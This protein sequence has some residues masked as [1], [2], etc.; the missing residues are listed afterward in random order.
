MLRFKQFLIEYNILLEDKRQDFI[1]RWMKFHKNHR[2]LQNYS[3]EVPNLIAHAMK[4]AKGTDEQQYLTTELLNGNYNPG[5]HDKVITSV[6]G[7]WRKG[8][9]A[10]LFPGL[11][12]SDFTH[13]SISEEFEKHSE[14]HTTKKQIRGIEGL[15]KYHIGSVDSETH[16]P[17]DVYH[18]SSDDVKNPE[19]YTKINRSLSKTCT[20]GKHTW[21][22]LPK[23]TGPELLEKYSKGHGIFFYANE[24]N[25][26]VLSHGYGD[27]NGLVERNNFTLPNQSETLSIK[28]QTSKLLSGYKKTKYDLLSGEH[29]RIS[30]SHEPLVISPQD[31]D[32]AF[33]DK[34]Y[35]VIKAILKETEVPS[36]YIDEAL[37]HDSDHVREA[38]VKNKGFG[39]QHMDQAFNDRYDMVRA[40]A[41]KSPHFGPEHM[42]RALND[43]HAEVRLAAVQSPYFGDE[44]MDRALYDW[45]PGVIRAA[46][47]HKIG[48]SSIDKAINHFR[49]IVR[50]A[51]VKSPNFGPQHMDLALGDS[52]HIVRA[53]AVKGPH[54]GPEHM[55]RALN[56][57]Y[58]F[59][60]TTAIQS[61]HFGPQHM[62]K[63]LNDENE[64]VRMTAVKSPH[65]GPEHI[66]KALNDV[67]GTVRL[68]A[69]RSPH[70]GPQHMDQALNDKEDMV[71]VA[72]V[73]SPNFG[74]EHMDKAL[75]DSYGGVRHAAVWS[76]HFGPEHVDK[77]L[78]DE[79]YQVRSR[80]NKKI[81]MGFK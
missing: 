54:F 43:T 47:K 57:E 38:A 74:P 46:L 32:R 73:E 76:P 25:N 12:L 16:G 36:H 50:I 26:M 48:A 60:R 5:E 65:F 63:A 44:H 62:D 9:E 21:C 75:N 79:D 67:H 24:H 77:A 56:D 78:K 1:N 23:D 72:A 19:E 71:R 34:H 11:K 13:D 17:L 39:P 69:A 61:P 31:M 70:F 20:G 4:F 7:K 3:E 40:E 18:V 58:S 33:Q 10:G 6:L 35:G 68:W 52:S 64:G 81:R 29:D 2:S 22:V 66:D 37:N 80:A 41:V 45:D 14:L 59:V 30:P 49:D 42:G 55:D 15:S 8:K 53:E 28:N 27:S 51:A